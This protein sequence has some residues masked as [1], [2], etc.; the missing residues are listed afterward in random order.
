LIE[1]NTIQSLGDG[2]IET[3][4]FVG[5]FAFPKWRGL[6]T[7]RAEYNDFSLLWQTSFLCRNVNT[8]DEYFLH[9]VSMTYR[10]DTFSIG[11]GVR[12][13]FDK[14][15]PRIDTASVFG[16]NNVPLGAGYDLNGRRIF[17]NFTKTF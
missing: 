3:N 15:P 6:A 8:A 9:N 17:A 2:I 16:S 1:R 10:A 14:N 13:V 4:E 12:N 7:A 11:F 5:E